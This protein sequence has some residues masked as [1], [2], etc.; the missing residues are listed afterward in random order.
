[1]KNIDVPDILYM[2]P[3]VSLSLGPLS[4][5]ASKERIEA[6]EYS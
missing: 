4:A 3:C 2:P 5:P 1:M 6:A